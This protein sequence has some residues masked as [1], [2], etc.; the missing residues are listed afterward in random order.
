M[1][2]LNCVKEFVIKT[3]ADLLENYGTNRID[4]DVRFKTKPDQQENYGKSIFNKI[5]NIADDLI[6]IFS[7]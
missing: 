2:P 3:K 4:E 6:I 1:V 7:P 5:K